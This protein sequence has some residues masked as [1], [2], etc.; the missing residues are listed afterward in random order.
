MGKKKQAEEEKNSGRERAKR[1]GEGKQSKKKRTASTFG[2]VCADKS[3][4]RRLAAAVLISL[5]PQCAFCSF[6]SLKPQILWQQQWLHL[7][8]ILVHATS[9]TQGGSLQKGPSRFTS[10]R[11]WS[12]LIILGLLGHLRPLWTLCRAVPIRSPSCLKA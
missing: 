5:S 4:Q 6:P 12:T 1:W 7:V 8:N 11:I 2:D 10:G 9:V 3:P